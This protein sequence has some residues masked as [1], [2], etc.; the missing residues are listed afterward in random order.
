M[1]RDNQDHFYVDP[2]GSL[3]CVADGMGGGQ[4]GA[5]ASEI[6]CAHL[7]GA[8][9]ST[10][11]F[12]ELMKRTADAINEANAEIMAYAAERKWRLMGSTLAALFIDTQKCGVGVLCH[13]GDSRIYRVRAGMLELLTNDHT[14]AGEIGR[15]TSCKG[16]TEEFARRM[17][18]LSH[19]LTRAIGIESTVIPDWR[20]IDVR[21]DDVYMIC[22]DGIYDMLEKD[23]IRDAL[24]KSESSAD[25]VADISRAVL[26]AGAQ[27]NFT[28]IVLKIGGET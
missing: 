16:L 26:D 27:D 18:R 3:Y 14:V 13:V 15:R 5:K 12:P 7:S 22:S 19:M 24:A 28:C 23:F 6:V 20:K 21:Q 25:A 1:R 10:S 4:G 9:Q 2:R 11:T 8:A 17:G